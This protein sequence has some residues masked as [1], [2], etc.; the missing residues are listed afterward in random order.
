MS[1]Q[2]EIEYSPYEPCICEMMAFEPVPCAVC[3]LD[4]LCTD[5]REHCDVCNEEFCKEHIEMHGCKRLADPADVLC[6][7]GGYLYNPV[8]YLG[9]VYRINLRTY[10]TTHTR[11]GSFGPPDARIF[12]YK[13]VGERDVGDG[14]MVP[15]LDVEQV[16]KVDG[17]SGETIW[18]DAEIE[19][20]HVGAES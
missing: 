20:A 19:A 12:E 3:K 18:D 6:L 9:E 10:F 11:S 16:G 7:E 5:C 8:E 15:N 2:D 1:D 17:T 4:K 14:C 13:G